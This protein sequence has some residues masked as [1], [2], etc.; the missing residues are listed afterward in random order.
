MIALTIIQHS[1]PDVMSVITEE[2]AFGNDPM[3]VIADDVN[4]I[5]IDG[6]ITAVTA[7]ITV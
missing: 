6:N 4:S 3:I 5:F 7:A 1:G 2:I